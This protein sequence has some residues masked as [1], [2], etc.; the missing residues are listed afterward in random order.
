MPGG[1]GCGD[2][3]RVRRLASVS[4]IKVSGLECRTGVGRWVQPSGLEKK[5]KGPP[6]KEVGEIPRRSYN[7]ELIDV[8]YMCT[9]DLC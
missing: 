2:L 7:S 4:E 8:L 1:R 3:C 6:K 5:K 9:V